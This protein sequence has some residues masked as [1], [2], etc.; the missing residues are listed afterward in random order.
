MI[1]ALRFKTGIFVNKE[2]LITLSNRWHLTLVINDLPQCDQVNH[3]KGTIANNPAQLP[4]VDTRKNL[5]T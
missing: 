5:S 4:E 1:Q 3:Q 2:L